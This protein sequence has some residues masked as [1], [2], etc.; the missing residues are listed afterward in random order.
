ML[1]VTR[2][3]SELQY[4][5]HYS[6]TVESVAVLPSSPAAVTTTK[7]RL[8]HTNLS[9]SDDCQHGKI[10]KYKFTLESTVSRDLRGVATTI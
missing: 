4:P 8:F 2:K 1:G 6:N 9:I 7:S 3:K 10:L 5:D